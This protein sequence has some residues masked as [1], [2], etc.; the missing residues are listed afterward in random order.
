MHHFPHVVA[1]SFVQLRQSNATKKR[2]AT[3]NNVQIEPHVLGTHSDGEEG[4][5]NAAFETKGHGMLLLCFEEEGDCC[6]NSKR[7]GSH[8]I[9]SV[10]LDG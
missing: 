8:I 2:G 5:T 7:M 3:S 10:G 1:C 4:K 9:P 6:Y